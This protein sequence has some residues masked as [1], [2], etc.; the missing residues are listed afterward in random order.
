MTHDIAS[1]SNDKIKKTEETSL[2][3]YLEHLVISQPQGK[4]IEEIDIDTSLLLSYSEAYK[5]SQTILTS[6]H[7]KNISNTVF[8]VCLDRIATFIPTVWACIFGN[9]SFIPWSIQQS[10]RNRAAF[11]LGLSKL[12]HSL[13]NSCAVITTKEIYEVIKPAIN[14]VP[15]YFFDNLL[16]TN[17]KVFHKPP[18]NSGEIIVSS[19]GTTAT[20]KLTRITYNTFLNRYYSSP[21]NSNKKNLVLDPLQSISGLSIILPK[22]KNTI[23]IHIDFLSIYPEKLFEIIEKHRLT[24]IGISP[25]IMQMLIKHLTY[26]NATYDLSSL[27][28]II[29]GSDYIDKDIILKFKEAIKIFTS[30]HYNFSFVYGMTECGPICFSE[31]D[32]HKIEKNFNDSDGTAN[33]GDCATSWSLRITSNNKIVKE[34]EKGHI[35]VFSSNKLFSGYFN[36]DN[37]KTFLEDGWFRTG[38]IGYIKNKQLYISGRSKNTLVINSKKILLEDIERELSKI[39]EVDSQNTY[40]RK[41]RSNNNL[42]DD[43]SIFYTPSNHMSSNIYDLEKLIESS[44]MNTFGIPVKNLVAIKSSKINRT[45]TGKK[46]RLHIPSLNKTAPHSYLEKIIA[47]LWCDTLEQKDYPKPYDHFFDKGG[48]SLALTAFV[49][50][51]EENYKIKLPINKLLNSLTYS[52]ICKLVLETSCTAKI[53]P[54]SIQ[55]NQ[56]NTDFNNIK[57]IEMFMASWKGERNHPNS[58]IIGKNIEGSS[59]PL[60]WVFQEYKEF[61]TLANSLG[62]DQ[63]LYGLK[64]YS[65]I[66]EVRNYSKETIQGLVDRYLWEILSLNIDLPFVMGGNC[67]GAIISLEIA[68]KLKQI[69]KKPGVLILMEWMFH[70]GGYNDKTVFL[71]GKNSH[72]APIYTKNQPNIH[73]KENF[74]NHQVVQIKGKHGQYFSSDNIFNLTKEIKKCIQQTDSLVY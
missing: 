74:P 35:E 2:S 19:S 36:T 73:W 16:E 59:P 20:P 12:I 44:I 1:S 9:Y 63:P 62:K 61:E 32:S 50:A 45:I 55:N 33:I 60:F 21:K 47:F 48:D 29:V 53:K 18:I 5:L 67:Q 70:F 34:G 24:S 27:T 65:K 37:K 64:S 71:Y 68:R 26:S 49:A 28:N 31:I 4:Y 72:T 7:N 30:S 43:L 66:L 57:Q 52:S 11:L 15:T 40:A 17:T 39:S 13:D 54:P 8:I 22:A 6:F 38:D 69:N 42:Y 10:S 51:I 25:Y 56:I 58:I 23:Y 46:R 41:E 3:S 14:E